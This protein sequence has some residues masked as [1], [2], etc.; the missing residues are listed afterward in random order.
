MKDQL[1]F[2]LVGLL[3]LSFIASFGFMVQKRDVLSA[4]FWTFIPMRW[5]LSWGSGTSY[6][7]NP[8]WLD[9][10]QISLIVACVG[11]WYFKK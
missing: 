3:V 1:Q 7:D 4:L 5:L 8:V 10:I 2:L 6:D 11:L 9:R